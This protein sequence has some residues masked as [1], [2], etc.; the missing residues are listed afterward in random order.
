M[1]KYLLQALLMILAFTGCRNEINNLSYYKKAIREIYRTGQY[2]SELRKAIEEGESEMGSISATGKPAVIFDIDET[3]L[4][5]YSYLKSVDFGYISE[6]WDRWVMEGKA[7]AIGPA[8][9]FYKRLTAKGF[10][11]IFITGRNNGQYSSTYKN[12]VNAGFKKFDTLIV[13]QNKGANVKAGETKE[14]ERVKLSKA[15][16]TVIACVGDQWSDMQG[17][18]TGKKIKLPNYI[19]VIE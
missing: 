12:L 19:Y 7:E 1:K 17:A 4:S 10:H 8:L 13:R 2:E 15:G 14:A 18:Y 9:D 11:I 16:Y 3:V 6:D 5:N